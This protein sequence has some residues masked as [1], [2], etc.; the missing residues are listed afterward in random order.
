MKKY[1]LIE[2]ILIIAV[3]VL[4]LAFIGAFFAI[5]YILQHVS[6]AP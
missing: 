6:F 3:L 1:S 5:R 2:K 4:A